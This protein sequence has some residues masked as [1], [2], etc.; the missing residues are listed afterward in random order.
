MTTLETRPSAPLL[1]PLSGTSSERA[2]GGGGHGYSS[3][4]RGRL[5]VYRSIQSGRQGFP[6]YELA[7]TVDFVG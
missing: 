5:C 2:R 4:V 7:L 6:P 3:R 1:S